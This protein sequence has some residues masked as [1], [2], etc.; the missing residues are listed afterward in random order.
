MPAPA[1]DKRSLVGSL[2]AT[3]I[4]HRKEI[5]RLHKELSARDELL[6]EFDRER[7][8]LLA[9]ARDLTIRNDE[10]QRKL[11]HMTEGGTLDEDD[12]A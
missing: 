1:T 9:V 4:A 3:C 8:G 11:D 10:L 2:T 5:Q 6:A 7:E 12:G